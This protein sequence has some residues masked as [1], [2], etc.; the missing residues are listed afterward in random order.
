MFHKQ[1]PEQNTPQQNTESSIVEEQA[2]PE[3]ISEEPNFEEQTPDVSIPPAT[4]YTAGTQTHQHLHKRPHKRLGL[5]LGEN[6]I[7]KQFHEPSPEIAAPE[8]HQPEIAKEEQRPET[9]AVETSQPQ[10]T[11]SVPAQTGAVA[12][13]AIGGFSGFNRLLP[14][15]N[16]PEPTSNTPE[17]A[18]EKTSETSYIPDHIQNQEHD[19]ILDEPTSQTYNEEGD[20]NMNNFYQSNETIQDSNQNSGIEDTFVPT[21]PQTSFSAGRQ[22]VVGEGISL[23]GEIQECHQLIVEGRV[24]AALKGSKVLEIKEGG[25]FIGAVEIEQAT[26]AGV[27]E[28]EITVNGRLTVTESGSITGSISYK[29]LEIEAG[30]KLD[31]KVSPIIEGASKEGTAKET[32]SRKVALKSSK[33]KSKKGESELPLT[34]QTDASQIVTEDA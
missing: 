6:D 30:A 23:N 4:G 21:V 8:T 14:Q 9:Q 15:Q 1:K 20:T 5:R 13:A 2:I 17:E 33:T 31:G 22:L 7:P 29:E 24:E 26:I 27:F 28:G 12:R 34:S 25:T 18:S 11:G 3:N 10:D 16:T 32:S 19:Q